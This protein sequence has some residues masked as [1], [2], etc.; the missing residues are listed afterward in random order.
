MAE[1]KKKACWY[2]VHTYS[3][4]ENKVK[5]N[6]E[7]AV[8]KNDMADLIQEMRVPTED[9]IEI[10][11]SKRV[12]T[13]RKIYPGYVLVKMIETSR[14]WYLVRN[15]R[16]VTGFVGPDSKPIP[17]TDEE[18]EMMLNSS[19][20]SVDFGIAIGEEIRILSGPLANF[21][22]LVSDVDTVRQKL[23][24]KVSLFQGR[25]MPV[26]VDLEQVEKIS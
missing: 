24:V 20:K 18:V 15:T 19:M 16:G 10:K 26:E 9:V 1:E 22:G 17:L 23:T 8:I 11:N 2:V 4:Y 12:K 21:T 25:E 5:D 6:L 7:K 13:Q 14:S 3:G